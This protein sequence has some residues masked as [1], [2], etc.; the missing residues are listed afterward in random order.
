[1][2]VHESITYSNKYIIPYMIDNTNL[3]PFNTVNFIL[4]IS[5]NQT[6]TSLTWYLDLISHLHNAFN[7]RQFSVRLWMPVFKMVL[8]SILH[9][10]N[11]Y[12]RFFAIAFVSMNLFSFTTIN[13]FSLMKI[14]AFVGKIDTDGMWTTLYSAASLYTI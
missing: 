1:M 5:Y 14:L 9:F 2:R 3:M 10:E 12:Y 8:D 7:D 6:D 11:F 13:I 4:H